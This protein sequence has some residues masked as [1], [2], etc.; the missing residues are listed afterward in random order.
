MVGEI[1]VLSVKMEREYISEGYAKHGYVRGLSSLIEAMWFR[2]RPPGRG[3]KSSQEKG[4]DSPIDTSRD[5][6]NS[7]GGGK[8]PGGGTQSKG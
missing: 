8:R 1:R 6:Y 2:R 7:N 4:S 3:G 5:S